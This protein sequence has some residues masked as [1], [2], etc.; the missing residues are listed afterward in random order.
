MEKQMN[1]EERLAFITSMINQA[2]E[3]YTNRSSFYFLLWGWV[4]SIANFSHYLLDKFD[5]YEFPFIVWLITIPA[6]LAS[7]WY[8]FKSSKEK[9]VVSHLDKVN[10]SLWISIFVMIVICLMFMQTINYNH[11]P[12]I[13]LFSGLGAF[14]SG[15]IMKYKPIIFGG[16]VLWIGACAGLLSSVL[17]QQ[18]I[19]GIA[20]FIGYL[21]PGYMLKKEQ[22]IHA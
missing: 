16:I 14:I 5:L 21:I 22:S 7:I 18:L 10:A 2:K 12:I 9:I 8:G 1:S 19:A 11:N 13:L 15:I 6:T 17:N 20:V 4:V 3:R